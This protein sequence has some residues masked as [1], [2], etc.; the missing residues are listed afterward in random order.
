MSGWEAVRWLSNTS[1]ATFSRCQPAQA[2]SVVSALESSVAPCEVRR[3]E[4]LIDLHFTQ[5]SYGKAVLIGVKGSCPRMAVMPALQA[6]AIGGEFS[7]V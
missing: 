6:S 4:H 7:R 3:G 5:T 2:S 1:K